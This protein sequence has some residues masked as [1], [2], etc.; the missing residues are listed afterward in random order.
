MGE[1][2]EKIIAVTDIKVYMVLKNRCFERKSF[3]K[4]NSHNSSVESLRNSSQILK[5]FNLQMTT[6]YRCGLGIIIQ[7]YLDREG[8]VGTERWVT[9]VRCN[10]CQRVRPLILKIKHPC[11]HQTAVYQLKGIG[12]W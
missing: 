2:S 6:P 8:E 4:T 10:N 5:N 12:T 11:S 9:A 3:V 7:P 1:L